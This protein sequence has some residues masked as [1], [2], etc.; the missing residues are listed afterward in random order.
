[1]A[2]T[3]QTPHGDL[4][5]ARRRVLGLDTSLTS[6]G[7]ALVD[8]CRQ[9]SLGVIKPPSSDRTIGERLAYIRKSVRA[10][11]GLADLAVIERPFL[12]QHGIT[13]A[14]VFGVVMAELW[15]CGIPAVEVPP[16][17]LK[18]YAAGTGSNARGQAKTAV[19]GAAVRRLGY[20]GNDDN[21]ADALWL[22]YLGWH[23]IDQPR[24]ELP[25]EHL[26]ALS[27]EWAKGWPTGPAATSTTKTRSRKKV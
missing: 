3:V 21:E 1:M 4:T 2:R 18:K 7:W 22:A 23:L 16:T 10:K 6:T 11:A 27:G 15:D 9:H 26:R 17:S 20:E 13:P 8:S 14:M 19:F 12:A 5:L 24:V 25:Q